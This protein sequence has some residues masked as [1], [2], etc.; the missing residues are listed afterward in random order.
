VERQI[1]Y[2]N[3]IEYYCKYEI[4]NNQVIIHSIVDDDS[5]EEVSS[6]NFPYYDDIVNILKLNYLCSHL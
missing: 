6:A 2:Y 4:A 5:G 1:V 3:I